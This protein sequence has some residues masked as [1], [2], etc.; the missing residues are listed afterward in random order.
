[1]AKTGEISIG[2]ITSVYEREAARIKCFVA[3]SINCGE[4]PDLREFSVSTPMRFGLSQEE[5]ENN[6]ELVN[7]LKSEYNTWIAAVAFGQLSELLALYLDDI[8][9]FLSVSHGLARG[10]LDKLLRAYPRFSKK[11]LNDKIQTLDH[12][13]SLGAIYMDVVRSMSTIRNCII[14]RHGIVAGDDLNEADKATLRWKGVDMTWTFGSR[15][16][17]IPPEHRG[18]ITKEIGDSV[19]IEIVMKKKSFGLGEKNT[20][21][22]PGNRRDFLEHGRCN[23]GRERESQYLYKGI[24]SQRHHAV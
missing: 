10:T 12:T 23:T 5:A 20:S 8:Y 19:K 16:G 13:Y 3:F 22:C 2:R 1:M 15:L 9:L 14:H 17:R 4:K 11:S 21:Q 7:L 24:G 18:P 6:P